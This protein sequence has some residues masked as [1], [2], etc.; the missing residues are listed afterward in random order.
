MIPDH[1]LQ[2]RKDNARSH[3]KQPSPEAIE[4]AAKMLAN[5]AMRQK[6]EHQGKPFGTTQ[7]KT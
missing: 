5:K 7:Q 4:I 1:V 2:E 3:A 6:Q